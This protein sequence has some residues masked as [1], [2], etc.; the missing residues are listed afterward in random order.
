MIRSAEFTFDEQ[1]PFMKLSLSSLGSV[2]VKTEVGPEGKI[3]GEHV[4][5]LSS[6]EQWSISA[7]LGN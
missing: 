1:N 7:L 4:Y 2:A 5:W 6:K 3:Y